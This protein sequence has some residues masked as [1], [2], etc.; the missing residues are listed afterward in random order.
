MILNLFKENGSRQYDI[1]G[2][3]TQDSVL[4]SLL[5]N[6]VYDDLLRQSLAAKVKLVAH[7]D[8]VAMV[9]VAKQLQEMNLAFGITFG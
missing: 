1:S 5:W 3:V 8:D 6:F 4:G 9:I 2:G 7:A